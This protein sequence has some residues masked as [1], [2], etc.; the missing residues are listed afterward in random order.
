MQ[1][2]RPLTVLRP[3]ENGAERRARAGHP[4][5]RQR[6]TSAVAGFDQE[7]RR[8][9]EGAAAIGGNGRG[10]AE[11]A[12]PAEIR[13]SLA[14]FAVAGE[15]SAGAVQLLDGR[16]Q[17]KSVGLIVGESAGGSQPLLEP[18]TYVERA[19]APTA[20]LLRSDAAEHER[21]GDR[22]DPTAAPRSSC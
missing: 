11:I 20:D 6:A 9:V 22:A 8:I 5:G 16:W 18:L 2:A 3:P 12:L 17:R 19:L 14:R 15:D 4:A 13:N 10:I 1:S 21:G 7:G